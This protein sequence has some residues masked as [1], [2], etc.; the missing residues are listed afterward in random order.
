MRSLT[1]FE[2]GP[3]PMRR[4]YAIGETVLDIIFK[5][6]HVKD[7]KPGGSMLNSAVSLGRAGLDVWLITEFA[8]DQ[9]GMH[10]QSFLE[11]NRVRCQYVFHFD[12]GK[13]P[14]ALAFLDEKSDASYVFY[15][16]YPEHRLS[17]EMPDFKE[18]DIILFGSFFGI[19]PVVRPR[20]LE[21]IHKA[22]EQGALIIYDPNFRK[23]HA[24]ELETLRPY[25][26]ENIEMSHIVRGSN[27][28]FKIIFDADSLHEVRDAIGGGPDILIMTQ[29]SEGVFLDSANVKGTFPVTSIKPIS[30][31]GAGDNFNAGFIYGLV[32]ENVSR[33]GLTRVS[34]NQWRQIAAY[35]VAF[36]SDVC[37]SFENYISESFVESLK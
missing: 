35:G 28:D 4:I 2:T 33:N 8:K 37:M 12:Q 9:V 16:S 22:R 13:T 1:T 7:A 36:A 20:I 14:L 18:T 5:D 23:P 32:K 29:S 24:H 19:D 15:K 26:M 31:I 11:Q 25:I 17:L 10:V 21:I 30:T 6:G 3:Q 34:E 27:E